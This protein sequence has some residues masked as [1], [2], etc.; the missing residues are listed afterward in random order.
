MKKYLNNLGLMLG[1]SYILF[2]VILT[3]L[4]V[5]SL[6]KNCN[7]PYGWDLPLIC[8]SLFSIVFVF[9]FLAGKEYKEK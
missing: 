3:I 2:L 5:G 7:K 4:D 1:I 8:L 6:P 9:G